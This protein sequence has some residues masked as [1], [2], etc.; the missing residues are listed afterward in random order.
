M[1]SKTQISGR[2][3]AAARVLIGVSREDLAVA[4]GIPVTTLKRIEASG[5]AIFSG[6]ENIAAVRNAL[7]NFGAVFLFEEDGIGA[8]VRLKFT[9][10]DAKQI[11]RLEGEGGVVREDDVP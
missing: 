1:S 6:E 9:R 2:Q 11:G 8:G 3:V 10:L 5:S 7:E 4:S